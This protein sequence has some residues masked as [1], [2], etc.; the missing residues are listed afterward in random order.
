[1]ELLEAW[2]EPH[3]DPD[4]IPV[5]GTYERLRFVCPNGHKRV[6]SPETF[7]RKECPA[8]KGLGP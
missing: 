4:F 8:C 3:I 7:L 1:M 5:V 6:V 2:D